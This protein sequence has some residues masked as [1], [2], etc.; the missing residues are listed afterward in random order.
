[1][2]G[3]SEKE[4]KTGDRGVAPELPAPGNAQ[5]R[6]GESTQKE[7]PRN[8]VDRR[9]FGDRIFY[10]NKGR[11]EQERGTGKREPG[12]RGST[13]DQVCRRSETWWATT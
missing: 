7:P 13:H 12:L 4:E 1:L 6:Q 10:Y 5:N 3:V 8:E 9:E 2:G 11:T